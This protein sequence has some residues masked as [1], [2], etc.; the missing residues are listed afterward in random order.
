MLPASEPTDGPLES[1]SQVETE[2]AQVRADPIC[3]EP[4][5]AGRAR[6]RGQFEEEIEDGRWHLFDDLRRA[7]YEGLRGTRR[8]FLAR[9]SWRQRRLEAGTA[10]EHTRVLTRGFGFS[11]SVPSRPKRRR[12]TRPSR[13]P[14]SSASTEL[15]GAA[16]QADGTAYLFR[17]APGAAKAFAVLKRTL[18]KPAGV[19][20]RVT[21]VSAPNLG[22]LAWAGHV[23]GDSEGAIFLW[24]R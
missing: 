2:L 15:K 8:L 14:A 18:E 21:A 19:S 4:L 11:A 10:R 16:N 6:N 12:R 7:G 1:S 3:D 22:E 23:T 13:R 24:Y 17:T 9:G 5:A 20:Q